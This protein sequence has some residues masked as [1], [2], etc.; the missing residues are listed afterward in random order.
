[1]KRSITSTAVSYVSDTHQP[2]KQIKIELDQD[3]GCTK[4]T[5]TNYDEMWHQLKVICSGLASSG[6]LTEK[7]DIMFMLSQDPDSLTFLDMDDENKINDAIKKAIELIYPN[8]SLDSILM[9]YLRLKRNEFINRLSVSHVIVDVNGTE[10]MFDAVSVVAT[11]LF[12]DFYFHIPKPCN[13]REMKLKKAAFKIIMLT[14]PSLM[15]NHTTSREIGSAKTEIA[16]AFCT[17]ILDAVKQEENMEFRRWRNKKIKNFWGSHLNRSRT[18]NQTFRLVRSIVAQYWLLE[19]DEFQIDALTILLITDINMLRSKYLLFNE[20]ADVSE[21]LL[22]HIDIELKMHFQPPR[23][24]IFSTMQT[25]CSIA[26]TEISMPI[27]VRLQNHGKKV[28]RF[29][30]K[31]KRLLHMERNDR[32]DLIFFGEYNKHGLTCGNAFTLEWLQSTVTKFPFDVK[33]DWLQWSGEQFV[34]IFLLSPKRLN[35]TFDVY[36]RLINIVYP[37]LRTY[38]WKLL[39]SPT[40]W[41][42]QIYAD[43]QSVVYL[44]QCKRR[45]EVDK[46]ILKFDIRYTVSD[47]NL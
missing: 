17:H 23:L 2:M 20:A 28:K 41:K 11:N 22:D 47:F 13:Q 15:R 44:E 26:T 6:Y 14:N 40:E 24:D 16:I 3:D 33:I 42:W 27:Q 10:S 45:L 35:L 25:E 38:L 8:G 30:K 12:N 4:R 37:N 34:R 39:S 31:F 1:M 19:T 18:M 21:E 5:E 9:Q 46:L 43:V 29:A 32:S 7:N 36:M